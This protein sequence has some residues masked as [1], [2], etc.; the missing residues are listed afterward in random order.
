MNKENTMK[1]AR[2]KRVYGSKQDWRC[3]TVQAEVPNQSL[4]I[5]HFW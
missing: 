1:V 5:Q 3:K 2:E 4:A